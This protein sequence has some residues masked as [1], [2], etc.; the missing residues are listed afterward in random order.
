[1]QE[2]ILQ[3]L[4]LKGERRLGMREEPRFVFGIQA[5]T[6]VP[7]IEMLKSSCYMSVVASQ[8]FACNLHQRVKGEI[9]A[10]PVK[11]DTGFVDGSIVD[12]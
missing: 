4:V 7:K 5:M 10:N 2:C 6:G 9:I 8:G 11:I 3:S 1:M 12:Q